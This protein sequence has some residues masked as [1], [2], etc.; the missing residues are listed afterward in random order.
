MAHSAGPNTG[1]YPAN[2]G[3]YIVLGIA[4]VVLMLGGMFYWAYQTNISGAVV[5]QG[6]LVVESSVKKVQHP[7]GGIVKEIYV[8]NGQ[9]VQAN[10]LLIR[11]DDTLTRANLQVVS[12]QLDE[13]EMREARLAAERD[14]ADEIEVPESLLSRLSDTNVAR[15]VEGEQTLFTSR[16]ESLKKQVEQLRERIAQLQKES[17]GIEAQTQAKTTEMD[18]IAEELVGLKTLELKKLITTNRM[19][20]MR[21][22]A[23]RLQGERGQLVASAAKA[24]GMI[25]EVELKILGME[26]QYKTDVIDE[27]RQVQSK[28]SELVERRVAAEDQ[29]KR[30]EVRAPRPGFVHQLAVH[31]VGGVVNASEPIM[32]IVPRDDRLVVEAR[33]APQDI[34]QLHI[35]QP[36][37][38]RFAAFNARTTPELFGSVSRISADL[39]Q[40]EVTGER[41]FLTRITLT[42]EEI[43]RLGDKKLV[44]GM[45]ADVQIRTSDRTALS[46]LVKP[47]QDQ[48]SK[49]FRER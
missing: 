11:L 23:A 35:D 18:L 30:I 5:T 8:K 41:Y 47:L 17:S 22:E 12:K 9:R 13:L 49:A 20:S 24:K 34:D 43:A 45:P 3:R 10:E 19:V 29:L 16:R 38:V 26:Q 31:T 42:D 4:V 6:T 1:D 15:I 44:P 25:A 33:V 2:V 32:L 46:F 7:T 40:D 39:S 27:L 28:Q 21:R 37:M 48:I 14:G 36:A